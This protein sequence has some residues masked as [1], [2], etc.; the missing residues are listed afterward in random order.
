MCSEHLIQG[1]TC[2]VLPVCLLMFLHMCE[3]LEVG[4]FGKMPAC[5]IKKCQALF[6]QEWTG[7]NILSMC[8]IA[9]NVYF[10]VF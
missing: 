9:C 1:A 4:V 2:T 10:L 3:P 6:L 5:I 7:G 8:C